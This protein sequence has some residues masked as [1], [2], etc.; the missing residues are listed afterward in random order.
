VYRNH[1]NCVT[2]VNY[3]LSILLQE[4]VTVKVENDVEGASEENATDMK[5]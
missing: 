1:K 2:K 5:K 3:I 4:N